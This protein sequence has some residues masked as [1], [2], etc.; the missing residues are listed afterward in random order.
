MKHQHASIRKARSGL[1]PTPLWWR[2]WNVTWFGSQ[3]MNH[4]ALD[5]FLLP[6]W[7]LPEISYDA[8]PIMKLLTFSRSTIVSV[9]EFWSFWSAILIGSDWL[10]RH[11]KFKCYAVNAGPNPC[12]WSDGSNVCLGLLDLWSLMNTSRPFRLHWVSHKSLC[13]DWYKFHTF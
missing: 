13:A 7:E 12:Q 10:R 9:P 1:L 2:C 3:V 6:S 11:S 5:I 8:K 4:F